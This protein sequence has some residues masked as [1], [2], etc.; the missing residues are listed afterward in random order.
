MAGPAARTTI[1]PLDARRGR[2]RRRGRTARSPEQD[3]S[4]RLA[5]RQDAISPAARRRPRPDAE[6]FGGEVSWPPSLQCG[7]RDALF[8]PDISFADYLRPLGGI[9]LDDGS[10]LLR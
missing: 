3:A 5:P 4:D 7:R 6:N 2:C 8:R 10:K 1:D 9:R